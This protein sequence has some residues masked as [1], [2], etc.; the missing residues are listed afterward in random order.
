MSDE[1]QDES[2]D[3]WVTLARLPTMEEA[4]VARSMLEA[5]GI[6]A[7]LAEEHTASMAWHLTPLLGGIRLMVQP[8]DLAR[9]RALF[10]RE[11]DDEPAEEPG[12]PEDPD[13]LE[14]PFR[15]RAARRAWYAA[16]IGLVILPGVL[17][18]YSL[19]LLSQINTPGRPL[20]PRAHRRLPWTL[21]AD[22]IGL[23]WGTF[24]LTSLLR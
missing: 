12:A 24:L 15:E 14:L 7:R 17:H 8:R 6:D 21:A 20:S 18:L 19:Y 1:T 4:Q 16:I 13:S 10:D 3:A 11:D 5:D 9:A 23:V 22:L 2:T